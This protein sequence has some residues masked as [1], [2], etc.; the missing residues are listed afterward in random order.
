MIGKTNS[1]TS[2]GNVVVEEKFIINQTD[3]VKPYLECLDYFK[4]GINYLGNPSEVRL[5]SIVKKEYDTVLGRSI[6]KADYPTAMF[7][8]G[9]DPVTRF[10]T[11]CFAYLKKVHMP[12]GDDG[13]RHGIRLP[14]KMFY[15]TPVEEIDIEMSSEQGDF[16]FSISDYC[17]YDTPKLTTNFDLSMVREVRSH[18]FEKSAAPIIALSYDAT[19]GD[20]AFAYSKLQVDTPLPAPGEYAYAGCTALPEFVVTRDCRKPGIFKDC[21]QLKRVLVSLITYNAWQ[22][23]ETTFKNTP[24]GKKEEGTGV[25]VW[26]GGHRGVYNDFLAYNSDLVNAYGWLDI[27]NNYT[28]PDDDTLAWYEDMDFTVEISEEERLSPIMGKRYYCKKIS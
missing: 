26:H 8:A 28:I 15:G 21:T 22:L 14:E 10:R 4:M 13:T 23:D 25:Y 20:Y 1:T 27:D 9:Y 7:M 16:I 6:F 12:R 2:V 19:V 11:G 17:F 5:S 3:A 18:A 24:I